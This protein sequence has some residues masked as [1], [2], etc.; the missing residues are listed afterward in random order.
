MREYTSYCE[1]PVCLTPILT[2]HHRI[3]EL[4]MGYTGDG[5]G[6]TGGVVIGTASAAGGGTIG[7][8]RA[9]CGKPGCCGGVKGACILGCPGMP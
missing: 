6:V 5:S 4:R 9:S 2:T 7:S 8:V 3:L 1:T